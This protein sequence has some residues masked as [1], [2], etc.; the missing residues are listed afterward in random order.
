MPYVHAALRS[1]YTLDRI[2]P[3]GRRSIGFRAPQGQW[4]TCHGQQRGKPDIAPA[5]PPILQEGVGV[6]ED[7]VESKKYRITDCLPR[8][9][10]PSTE[11]LPRFAGTLETLT[12]T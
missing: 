7:R 6:L 5:S 3:S 9:G 1:I 10:N 12:L 11:R 2:L 4:G 8:R